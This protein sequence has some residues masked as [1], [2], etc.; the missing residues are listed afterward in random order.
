VEWDKG[1]LLIQDEREEI[2]FWTN[3]LRMKAAR[4]LLPRGIAKVRLSSDASD[5]G[6]GGIVHRKE[7]NLVTARQL[8]SEEE[9]ESSTARE[10]RGILFAVES[11][12]R[13]LT[14]ESAILQCDNQGAVAITAKGSPK[15][16]L[17]AIALALDAKCSS[18]NC[19]LRVIWIPRELNREADEASR[20]DDPDNGGIQPNVFQACQ[21]KW[22]RFTIDRF[23]DHENSHCLRFNSNYFVPRTEAVDCLGENWSGDFN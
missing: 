8:N 15:E 13:L 16:K 10:S 18:I 14:G 19:D 3:N 11:F 23:A 7:G 22:G 21:A 6:L 4:S 12:E 17:N 20:L 5:K 2:T 1:L 9:A